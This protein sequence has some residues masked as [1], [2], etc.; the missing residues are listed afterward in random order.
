MKNK[1]TKLLA[2]SAVLATSSIASGVTLQ[3]DFGLADG[4][5]D[6][7]AAPAGLTSTL[8]NGDVDSDVG[9]VD[10]GTLVDIDGNTTNITLDL[11]EGANG[12]ADFFDAVTIRNSSNTD[13]GNGILG[14][15]L[16]Q[17]WLFTSGNDNLGA[18]LSG[19]AA[20]EYDVFALVREPNQLGRTYDVGI[21]VGNTTDITTLGVQAIGAAANNDAF[22]SGQNF[23][24]QRVTITDTSDFI[25]VLVD[26][27]NAG[28]GTLAGLQ[29]VSVV[30]EPSSVALLGLGF[31]SFV[32]RR[33][34]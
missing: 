31:M 8:W 4:A 30:P 24:Q 17:D 29:I 23:V 10:G 18:R 3:I 20:G 13:A 2:A 12:A 26:P 19:F 11:G 15:A 32:L 6:G 33:K 1:I 14:T 7:T 28:F 27:T 21:G 25:T 9:G 22:V 16:Y 34:R 5:F